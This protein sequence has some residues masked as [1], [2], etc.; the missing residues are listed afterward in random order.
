MVA[1]FEMKMS[2]IVAE[3]NLLYYVVC[4]SKRL[5]HSSSQEL[6]A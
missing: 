5:R 4:D 3:F 2:I 6:N 1:I